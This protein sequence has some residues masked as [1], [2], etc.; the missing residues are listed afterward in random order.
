MGA[1]RDRIGPCPVRLVPMGLLV[2]LRDEKGRVLARAGEYDGAVPVSLPDF[3]SEEFPTLRHID[4]YGNTMFNHGQ[5][6]VVIPEL[7]R[8]RERARSEKQT[9]MV[10]EV[11]ALALRCQEG[12]HTYLW[13][14]GD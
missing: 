10:D 9:A 12:V 6:E 3:Q 4:L 11:I 2:E 1:T 8:L 5:L 14:I 7:Q 13:F